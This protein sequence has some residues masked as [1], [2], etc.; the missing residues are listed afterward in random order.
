[1]TQATRYLASPVQDGLEWTHFVGR[2]SAEGRDW[3]ADYAR[4]RPI[5]NACAR[6]LG[7]LRRRQYDAGFD[8]LS[9]VEQALEPIGAGQEVTR[10][11]LDRWYY[12][13]LAYY[14]YCKEAFDRAE[15]LMTAAHQAVASAISR[16][17]FLMPLANHCHEFR[18]HK[19]RIARNRR[20]W[21]AMRRY[22]DQVRDMMEDRRPFCDLDDGSPVYLSSIRDF[23]R[24]LGALTPS[25]T[26]ALSSLLDDQRRRLLFERFVHRLYV[27]PGF[28]IP[29]P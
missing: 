19:A 20:D 11:V 5:E 26:Q 3:V 13:V 22:V 14:H 7:L 6:A 27:L 1:M 25:E 23:Y 4:V 16:G 2:Q 15:T 17:R 10:H 28:V 18:L 24:S 8:E 12:G 21:P 29:Y 9:K